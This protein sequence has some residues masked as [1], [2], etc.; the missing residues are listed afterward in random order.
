MST[1]R[2]E[3]II[4]SS[5]RLFKLTVFQIIYADFDIFR[6]MKQQYIIRAFNYNKH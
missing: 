1:H 2:L 6:I 4:E 3:L 5:A